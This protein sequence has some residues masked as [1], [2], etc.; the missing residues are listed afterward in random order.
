MATWQSLNGGGL[1]AGIGS[2]NSNAP[3]ARDNLQTLGLIQQNNE[4]TR[5][6]GNNVGLQA[7]QGL[8]GLAGVYQQDQQQKALGAFNQAHAQAWKTGD[9]SIL[10]E[11]AAT[12][13]AFV[14]QAQQA[15]SGL[16][17]Q[18]RN[19]MGMLA[20]GANTALAQGPEAFGQYIQ[21]NA[22]GL[23]RVGADPNWML[24][25][26]MQNPDQLSHLATTLA[27]GA[28]GPEKAF[29][30]K[31]KMEG[32]Q[33]D[34]ATL[35][36]TARNNDMTN[37]RGIRGQN[38]SR[39]N[40]IRSGSGSEGGSPP[41]SVREYQYFQ[42]LSPEQQQ[43][44]LRVNGRKGGQGLRQAQLSNGETVMISP[45]AQG[46]G[47][48]K[49]YEGVDVDG[50]VITV[51]A[52]ALSSVANSGTSAARG[53]MN[54]DLSNIFKAETSQLKKF[55]GVTG[56]V[57]QQALGADVLSRVGSKEDRQIYNSAR[58]IQGYQQNQ[59]IAAAREMGASGINTV[60]EA[61]MYF[62]SQPQLDFASPE[63]L[64][65]SAKLIDDYTKAFNAKTNANLGNNQATEQQPTSQQPA[66]GNYTSK[67]GIQ[68]TVK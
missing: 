17:E 41:S 23:K 40:S 25:S 13:P 50:N 14:A 54:S 26:G 67:S 4:F 59:G 16:D 9:N 20:M 46:A 6:G 12:N 52:T 29:A 55:T 27:M 22:E 1:L 60:A 44:Y 57:G 66:G 8:G 45:T 63:S 28:L 38:I 11:F 48:A 32:R 24:Q 35:A 2:Q 42:G 36:E 62:Q 61:K 34:R 53:L 65:A 10:R 15:V 5:Q 43:T 58:R 56:T 19:D 47:G 68:F 37:A 3:Q 49:Y 21:Q 39:E 64:V 31:D 33:N 18:Q 51:P 7:L 30:V